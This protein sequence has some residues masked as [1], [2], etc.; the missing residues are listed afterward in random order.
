MGP[1]RHVRRAEACGSP[2]R[3]RGTS[4]HSER[5]LRTNPGV[6]G[7]PLKAGFLKGLSKGDYKGLGFNRIGF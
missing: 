4:A 5:K 7:A 3:L 1:R 6:L 2:G